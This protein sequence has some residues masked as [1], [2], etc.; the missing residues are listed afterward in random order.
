MAGMAHREQEHTGLTDSAAQP[1]RARRR[2]ATGSR[3]TRE[4]GTAMAQSC[5][6]SAGHLLGLA[7]G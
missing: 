4:L 3:W 2:R 5:R 6:Y 1:E 7:V